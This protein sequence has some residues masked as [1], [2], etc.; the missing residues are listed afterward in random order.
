MQ[1]SQ[2]LFDFIFDVSG[3]DFTCNSFR[4]GKVAM[5]DKFKQFFYCSL[6]KVLGLVLL[7]PVLLGKVEGFEC[8]VY[9]AA[10][11]QQIGKMDTR[12]IFFAENP[13]THAQ[14]IFK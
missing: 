1:S 4:S 5:A 8:L 3:G 2:E 6:R 9:A 13:L 10:L 11:Q 7:K 14:E 12:V